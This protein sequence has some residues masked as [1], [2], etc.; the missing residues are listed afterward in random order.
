MISQQEDLRQVKFR[1]Y[2]VYVNMK[3]FKHKILF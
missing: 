3:Y 1:V 2:V